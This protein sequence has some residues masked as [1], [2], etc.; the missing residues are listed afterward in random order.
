MKTRTALL[1]A[2]LLS[3]TG[4]G[5]TRKTAKTE[6]QTEQTEC[7]TEKMAK[8][9]EV[10]DYQNSMIDDTDTEMEVT[11]IEYYPTTKEDG[12]QLVKSIETKTAKTRTDRKTDTIKK[13]EKQVEIETEGHIT[14]NKEEKTSSKTDT[15][16]GVKIPWWLYLIG[17]V[18]I[19]I[20]LHYYISRK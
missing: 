1:I 15:D 5:I 19:Y 2:I 12:A 17:L 3:L 9:I 7:Q 14:M 4:C 16:T 11:R 20:S 10:L 8:D 13:Q 18:A 6:Y